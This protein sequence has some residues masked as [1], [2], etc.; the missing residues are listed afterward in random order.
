[1]VVSI[2]RHKHILLVYPQHFVYESSNDSL[3]CGVRHQFALCRFVS[4]CVPMKY[5]RNYWDILYLVD[6]AS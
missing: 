2:D 5:V 6:S 4:S 1:M 3:I